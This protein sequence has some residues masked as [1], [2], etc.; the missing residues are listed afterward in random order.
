MCNMIFV[1]DVYPYIITGMRFKPI[2]QLQWRHNE[3]YGV[4]NHQPHDGLLNC[5]F[6]RRSK[7]ISELRVTGLCVGNSPVTGYTKGHTKGQ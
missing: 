1:Y 3:R 6:R 5:L 7:K 2:G 4:S